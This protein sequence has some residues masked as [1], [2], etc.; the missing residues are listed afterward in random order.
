[1][2]IDRLPHI[3]SDRIAC[4]QIIAEDQSVYSIQWVVL[5]AE[6][7]EELTAALVLQQYLDYIE[8]VTLK[9]I[10]VVRVGRTIEFRVA[11]TAL[12]LLSFAQPEFEL[13]GTGEKGSLLI[14]GGFLVQ[15]KECD[16]GRLDFLIEPV[17]NGCRVALRMSDYC[18]LILGSR[19]PA[20]WRKWLYRFTQAYLHKVIAVGFLEGLHE[21]SGGQRLKKGVVRIAVRKGVDT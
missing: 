7:A 9:I 3:D 15:P 20:Q 1:M 8:R 10:R 18:P 21:K 14:S 2:D 12:A 13:Q 19:Q 11:G 17:V 4:Q 5:P 16:R 6:A